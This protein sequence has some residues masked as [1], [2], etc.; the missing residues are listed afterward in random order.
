MREEYGFSNGESQMTSLRPETRSLLTLV[1]LLLVLPGAASAASLAADLQK[2]WAGQKALLM[3]AADAMPEASF[4]SRPTP[5]Q[6]TFKEQVLHVAGAN[7]FL[8]G[9][10][11]AKAEGPRVDTSNLATFGLEAATKA[12]VLAALETSFDHGAAALGEFTDD[13][14]LEE[15][16][17][18]PW[19]GK[20][21]RTGMISFILGHNMDLYGQMVVYLRLEGVVPPASRR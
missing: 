6:R 15:V 7:S 18:P 20:V 3:G 12:E 1:A 10:V 17:G 11:G 13:A 4:G 2:S 21:T 5:E 9:F 19:V 8:M 16:Q 14:M